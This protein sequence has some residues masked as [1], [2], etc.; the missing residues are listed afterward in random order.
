MDAKS[1][2]RIRAGLIAGLVTVLVGLG[3][4]SSTIKV[5]VMWDN[6][7]V[8]AA[9]GF[10]GQS[11]MTVPLDSVLDAE[12]KQGEWYKVTVTKDGV[13]LTGYIHEKL[14]KEIT[15]TEA[16][17]TLSP[18]GRVRSQEEIVAGIDFKMEENKR[19]IRQENDP[20]KAL[21][22]LQPL[23][24]EAFNV[25][26]HLK[27]KHIA[28]ELYYW[29]G[30]ANANKGDNY[31]ALR[32]FQN[33]IEV[34]Y[35]YSKEI[36][37]NIP[38]PSVSGL[39]EQAEK[40]SKGLL[41]EYSLQITTRPRDAVLKINGK[42]IGISPGVHKATIP[43]CT[44]DI[45]KEGYKPIKEKLFLTQ[46]LT[47]KDYALESLGRNL[48][49]SSVPKGAKVFLDG[50]DSGKQT[51]CELP[52]QSYGSH[53]VKLV[54]DQYA[55]WEGRAVIDEGTG[56]VAL[57]AALIGNTYVFGQK[58]GG[59]ENNFF[60]LPRA[61]AFDKLGNFFIV[62]ESLYRIKKFD[63]ESLFQASWGNAGRESR[64][65]RVPAGI[66]VD[67]AGN[68]YV[69]DAKACC[70]AKFD[71][72]GKFLK[73]WG[74]EGTNPNELS[75]PTGITIDSSE[76]LYVA[77]TNNNRVVKYSSDGALKKT[78]GGSGTNPGEF[79]LPTAL[80]VGPM[81]EVLVVDRWRLQKF[82][83]EGEPLGSWGKSGS[84]DGEIK[85]PMGVCTDSF[86]CVY[87]ADTGNNRILKFDP[88]GKLIS[89][90]GQ[91]GT[92]DG[93]MMEPFGIAVSGKGTVFVV[94]REN[95]RFQ[96]FRIPEK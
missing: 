27:Q 76:N 17:Q 28:C 57:S 13:L 75:G 92:G 6:S 52:F 2:R 85:V 23:I 32:E 45:E 46:T 60:K 37:K 63:R 78:W 47:V 24:A 86:N 96:E 82:S 90:W 54:R 34:D 36:T 62:D 49:L 72:S 74:G 20:D 91:P 59:P 16:Q 89:Q 30:L 40:I 10:G 77:D 33:M 22:G 51:D 41:V 7:P 43:A 29:I 66:A 26:D 1:Q 68:V 5:R 19:L 65:L 18:S 61:I 25:E 58:N 79:V 53:A 14:V 39:I 50:K 15:E 21:T 81:N 11:L 64:V 83:P 38:D 70:V 80:T 35:A 31:E 87:I 3:F 84:G 48:A 71:K 69:T 8:K 44:L 12:G 73:K 88:S 67:G 4:G 42:P 56:P 95:Q 9:P 93:Q 55:D 94:E